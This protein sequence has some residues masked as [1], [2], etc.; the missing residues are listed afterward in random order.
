MSTPAIEPQ[1]LEVAFAAFNEQSG[2]LESC[3][4][5]LQERVEG[6]TTQLRSAHSARHRE[7]LEKERLSNRLS[8]IL[9]TLPGAFLVV[10]GNGII[11]ERNS[12]AKEYFN[13][14]LLGCYWSEILQRDFSPNACIDGDL[15]LNDGRWLNLFRRSLELESGEILLLTDVTERRR[16]SEMMQWHE[17]MSSIGEMTASLTHQI[18]TP[19]SSALLYLSQIEAEATS[20]TKRREIAGK[21]SQCLRGLDCLVN[22]MLSFV[23]GSPTESGTIGVHELLQTVIASIEPQLPD[24]CYITAEMIDKD[25]EVVGNRDALLGALL[26]LVSNALQACGDSAVI[27]LG[28]IRD[29]DD[30]CMSVS[31]TGH[32]IAVEDRKKIFDPFYTTRPNGT[33]L[34]LAVVRRVAEAHDGSVVVESNQHGS[35][36]A[37]CIPARNKAAALPGGHQMGPRPV[38]RTHEQES[39]HS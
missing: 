11:L 38:R 3:Y 28:A 39:C 1:I 26:N 36:F 31:D 18:R 12:Q 9:E 15:R 13:E 7:L 22:D 16:V 2:L 33:G 34:G 30:I 29:G 35:T 19:L 14:P 21:A 17:R 8:H 32:G 20:D 6:L 5:D 37:I 10:D 25:L 4:R 27:E 23:S 24:C